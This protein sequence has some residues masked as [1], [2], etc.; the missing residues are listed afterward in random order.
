[1]NTKQKLIA[2]LTILIASFLFQVRL[3]SYMRQ[4]AIDGFYFQTWS[5][6]TL[7]QTVSIQDLRDAPLE[8]LFNIHIQPPGFDLIRAI[9]VHTL[10]KPNEQMPLE[11]YVDYWLYKL[12]A[13]FY[14]I[15]GCIVFLWIYEITKAKSFSIVSTIVFLLHPAC[16]LFATLLD[17]TF[18]TSMLILIFYYFL[19]KTKNKQAVA[20]SYFVIM[21]L[22]LF[23]TRSIF[24][25]PFVFVSIISLLLVGLPKRNVLLVFL[26]T[27]VVTGLYMAKQYYQFGIFSTSSFTGLNLNRSVGIDMMDRYR[28]YLNSIGN[29]DKQ[30]FSLPR[31]L[32]RKQKLT[33][34]PN[35]NNIEY[36]QLNRELEEEF[37]T[38]IFSISPL[39]LLGSY[40]ENIQI[41]FAPSS[42]ATKHVIVDRLP[43]R[44]I[45]D[46]VFS[47]PLIYVLFLLLGT[48]WLLER[49]RFRDYLPSAGI[50][51]PGIFIFA[52][53][54]LFEKG[55]NVRFKFFLEPV[56][57]VFLASQIY[58][59]CRKV[60]TL[61]ALGGRV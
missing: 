1:M 30:D 56:I 40:R 55:E 37:K 33:G 14:G 26:V 58:I 21:I 32:T 53:C 6:E 51:L 60:L 10:P 35:Y 11:Q 50:L 7:M 24:Q 2:S 13:L 31:T 23:F 15:L 41:Y 5:S 29:S 52:I 57:F 43:W 28:N 16:L 4:Y 38:Y 9:I 54:V 36:L 22:A 20:A 49:I 8:T 45:Y 59:L 3:Q 34:R 12:W 46:G 19:W 18:L 25:L 61:L 42:K 17:S 47:A 48:P 44:F 27:S 39:Q